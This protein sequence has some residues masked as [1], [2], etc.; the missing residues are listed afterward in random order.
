MRWIMWIIFFVGL[1]PVLLIMYF[2]LKGAGDAT[3]G[4]CFAVSVKREWLENNEV[5][6]IQ[7]QY[8]RELKRVCLILAVIPLV[9]LILPTVSIPFAI[10]MLWMVAVCIVP[11]F[12]LV[13]A[14]GRLKEW[15]RRNGFVSEETHAIYT[16]MK[17][18][19]T[20]RRVKLLPF[21]L[22]ILLSA[23]TAFWSVCYFGK[24]ELW[25]FGGM[26][27]VFALVTFLCYGIAAWMDTQKTQ[28]I[29]S[30]SD[31][32]LNY[33][34]AKKNLWKNLWLWMAWLNTLYTAAAAVV[35]A[36]DWFAVEWLLWL[37]AGYGALTLGL[38]IWF[39]KCGSAIE[40]SYEGK[41]EENFTDDD[42]AW[43][44]GIVYYNKKDKR[45][46]VTKRVGIGTTMNLA[47]PAGKLWNGIG[48]AVLLI[49]VPICCV[50]MMLEEFTPIQLSVVNDVLTA[51][52][53][54]V[55]Y[56]IPVDEMESI[57]I[58]DE[59]PRWTKVSG[60]GMENLCKGT[61]RIQGEKC[62]VFV[63][64]QNDIFLQIE[65]AEETY[66]MSAADDAGTQ[67]IY[68]IIIEALE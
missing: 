39:A 38:L 52:Q 60:S 3:G 45:T 33:T 31:V 47:T 53:F 9:T 63:N 54:E 14:N 65:T 62:E 46:M 30:D 42:D 17:S 28:V 57:A 10:W 64:P 66:Y 5:K 44:G 43:L 26:I 34:R 13:R 25:V 51:E 6:E 22:P 15:K 35:F 12:P 1:Y 2:S 18:A 67:E 49:V 16:E 4:Y 58:I 59:K 8:R 55:D 50:W 40:A 29:S 27:V 41:R 23:G 11:A 21:L 56:E 7:E 32:N 36:A 37:S 68:E 20:V 24:K 19:G 61:F 48:I